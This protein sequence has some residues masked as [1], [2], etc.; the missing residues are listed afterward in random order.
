ME[1]VLQRQTRP[2]IPYRLNMDRD[3]TIRL[4][5]G[6]RIY[7]LTLPYGYV[8]KNAEHSKAYYSLASLRSELYM[9]IIGCDC[10]ECYWKMLAG[11]YKRKA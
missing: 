11:I 8:F 9:D 6:V 4:K 10:D 5:N 7:Q 1:I 2:V 3:V